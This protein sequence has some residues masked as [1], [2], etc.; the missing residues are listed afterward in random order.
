M[1][2]TIA[3]HMSW[4]LPFLRHISSS[5]EKQI[6]EMSFYFTNFSTYRQGWYNR[7][8]VAAV[9]KVPPHKFEK[10]FRIS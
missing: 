1:S 8:V 3:K 4:F 7:P 6:V 10:K 5:W 9:P 2:E